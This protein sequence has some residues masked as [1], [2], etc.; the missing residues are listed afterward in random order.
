M[1]L[2]LKPR[3]Q[4]SEDVR[5]HY[6]HLRDQ[7]QIDKNNLDEECIKQPMLYQSLSE[8]HVLA[9]AERD[10]LKESLAVID[11]QVAEELRTSS[12][13]KITDKKCADMV[14]TDARHK[15]A[16]GKWQ[17]A[18]KKAAYLQT[19]VYAADQRGKMLRELAQLFV[20]GYFDRVTAGS[21][22]KTNDAALAQA[23]RE[24]MRRLRNRTS[25]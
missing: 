6:A 4:A 11:A 16:Y 17:E 2:R 1:T 15:Q 3:V 23:G 14:Q 19:L 13:E 10:T 8:E 18:V 20:A 5:E 21:S 24:G 7:L 22:R 9:V 25:E 12:T